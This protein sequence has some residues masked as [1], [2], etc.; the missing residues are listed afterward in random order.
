M[1]DAARAIGIMTDRYESIRNSL[2]VVLS[3]GGGIHEELRALKDSMQKTEADFQAAKAL[4]G[5][6]GEWKALTD[7]IESLWERVR[8]SCSK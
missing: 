1:S 4:P 7:E 3:P 8:S 6:W 2:C 5:N